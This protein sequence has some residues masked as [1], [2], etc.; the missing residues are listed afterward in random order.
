MALP[1]T[2]I[3]C[4]ADAQIADCGEPNSTEEDFTAPRVGAFPSS[5][6]HMGGSQYFHWAIQHHHDLS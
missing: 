5:Q 6:P 3:F 4:A 1:D 2:Q